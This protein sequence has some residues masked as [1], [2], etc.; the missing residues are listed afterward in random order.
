M[1]PF[2][3]R[4]DII[5]YLIW[6]WQRVYM[7]NVLFLH[8]GF[9][10]LKQFF[11]VY[12]EIKFLGRKLHDRNYWTEMVIIIQYGCFESCQ[13]QPRSVFFVHERK[14]ICLYE[15]IS[16]IRQIVG[17]LTLVFIQPFPWRLHIVITYNL[18]HLR[19]WYA[20]DTNKII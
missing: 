19:L 1:F 3:R 7:Y 9:R 20:D 2:V 13:F 5:I 18:P 6:V 12:F 4:G 10:Y 17:Y 15:Y 16:D 11:L 8:I 14:T